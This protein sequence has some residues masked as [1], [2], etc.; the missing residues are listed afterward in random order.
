LSHR[1]TPLRFDDDEVKSF[2]FSSPLF[3]DTVFSASGVFPYFLFD[4]PFFD[5]VSFSLLS[6]IKVQIAAWG[7]ECY[8]FSGIL[9][10][11]F[12]LL[13][14]VI[15]SFRFLFPVFFFPPFCCALPFTSFI[16]CFSHPPFDHR[17]GCLNAPK[18]QSAGKESSL[19]IISPLPTPSLLLGT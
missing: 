9:I 7:I 19:N 15:S 11:P 4:L 5:L 1:T 6:P 13:S 8:T 18:V 3:D 2:P 12:S 17:P 14:H 10:L 16:F